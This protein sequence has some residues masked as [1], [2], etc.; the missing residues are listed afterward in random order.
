MDKKKKEK[1]EK[2]APVIL[3]VQDLDGDEKFKDI[4]P[5]LCQPPSLCLILGAIKSSKSNLIINFL[6]NPDMYKDRFDIVRVLSTT[7]HMDN[8]MKLLDKYFDCDD[9]YEDAYI[10]S[11]I[12]S[13][14]KF[15]KEE[16]PTYCLVL[17]DCLSNDFA[18]R[19][20]KLAYFSAK[21]RHYIDMLII[22]SQSI[23]HIPPIIRANCRNL[24]MGKAQNHKEL[25]KAQEQFGGLLGEDGDNLF[26][27]LYNY[28]HKNQ[29]YQFFYMKLSENPIICFKN[30]DEK[31]FED[32][33]KL[34]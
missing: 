9:H 18:K 31:I 22:S 34:F 21:M 1:R 32:G 26:M 16:R 30:F 6:C 3:K 28:C 11:I 8:K 29:M 24:I 4:H 20:N 27:E 17:D 33:K 13:Q 15:S 5:N 7:L 23:N 2:K 14:G 25:I 10:D 19:N 12:E